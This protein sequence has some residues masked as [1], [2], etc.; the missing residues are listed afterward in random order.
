MSHRGFLLRFM[1]F[2][3][4]QKKNDLDCKHRAVK[5]GPPQ[6]ARPLRPGPCLDFGFQY[7]LIR[8]NRSKQFGAQCLALHG[9]NSPDP[10]EL[11]RYKTSSCCLATFVIVRHDEIVI[12]LDVYFQ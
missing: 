3:T 1:N 6:L 2:I 12:L 9:S 5:A 10:C 8:N 4:L 7:A 11:A